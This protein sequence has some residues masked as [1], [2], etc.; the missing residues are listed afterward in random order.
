MDEGGQMKK[1]NQYSVDC[2]VVFSLHD[3]MDPLLHF[4][5]FYISSVV[6]NWIL[7]TI[8]LKPLIWDVS[9]V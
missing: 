4:D 2:A 5:C 3:S 8:K 7:N 9:V 6:L 1:N